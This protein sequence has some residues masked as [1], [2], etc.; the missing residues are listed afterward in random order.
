MAET[1]AAS[2]MRDQAAYVTSSP[3]S[4]GAPALTGR[5]VNG[6]LGSA[7]EVEY[8]PTAGAGV[9]HSE[10]AHVFLIGS[11]ASCVVGASILFVWR[12]ARQKDKIHPEGLGIMPAGLEEGSLRI[13]VSGQSLAAPA[14]AWPG[15]GLV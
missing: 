15:S 13:V 1:S 8:S 5:E 2:S 9:V 7:G 12:H 4:V 10:H 3:K 11:I 14:H 6:S